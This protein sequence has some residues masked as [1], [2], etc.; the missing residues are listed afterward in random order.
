MILAV[1]AIILA[2]ALLYTLSPLF[3]RRYSDA[4]ADS[5]GDSAGPGE[6]NELLTEKETLLAAIKEIDFDYKTG[7]LSDEDYQELQE[8]YK[9]KALSVMEEIDRRENELGLAL[10]AEVEKEIEA[11]RKKKKSTQTLKVMKGELHCPK[12]SNLYYGGDKF[13]PSCG[14]VV[15]LLC[16][17]CGHTLEKT[18][19]YCPNCGKTLVP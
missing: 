18:D 12:C 8:A 17:S 2:L 11:S 9:S 10:E 3:Q 13:C 16:Q 19:R 7:K 14:H 15:Q 6:I 4:V 1:I 5:D